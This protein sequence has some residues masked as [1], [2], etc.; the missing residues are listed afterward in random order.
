MRTVDA[1]AADA[2]DAGND[3]KAEI[4]KE[5]GLELVTRKKCSLLERIKGVSPTETEHIVWF[6][7]E[8][9]SVAK[10]QNRPDIRELP[11]L[12]KW[13]HRYAVVHRDERVWTFR[14][15]NIPLQD[16]SFANGS[17]SVTIQLARGADSGL[18]ALNYD[19][20][21]KRLSTEILTAISTILAGEPANTLASRVREIS[22]RLRSLMNRSD[23]PF[24]WKKDPSL[25]IE[26]GEYIKTIRLTNLLE[27]Q[28][29][30][31]LREAVARLTIMEEV[32]KSRL[33]VA[34][35]TIKVTKQELDDIVIPTLD[36]IKGKTTEFLAYQASKTPEALDT[37]FKHVL[38]PGV[39]EER[40]LQ[41]FKAVLD[42]FS[43]TTAGAQNININT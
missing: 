33:T 20:E 4:K 19:N 5:E 25:N 9:D 41:I 7:K 36:A 35:W 1:R 18:V 24:R 43:Q 16:N 17:L 26:A 32:A 6:T 40:I 14:I 37:F 8:Q 31:E 3:Q 23:S 21:V 13:N 34:L 15:K 42:A 30:E 38:G 12:W 22:N 11:N 27:A 39:R 2:D 29:A 10:I 28:R